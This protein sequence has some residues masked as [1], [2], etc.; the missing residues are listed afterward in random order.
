MLGAS[1]SR[2]IEH[3]ESPKA[4]LQFIHRVAAVT[5]CASSFLLVLARADGAETQ[6]LSRR[7]PQ[8]AADLAPVGRA[9][10]EQ[11]L[12]LSI[13]LPLRNR[14]ALNTLVQQLYDPASPSY[15]HYLT[16]E[17]FGDMFGA[18]EADYQAVISFMQ[19]NGLTV[20]K[21]HPNRLVVDV[22]GTVAEVERVMHVTMREYQHPREARKFYAPDVEPS[23][24]LS[25]PILE[26]SGLNNYSRRRPMLHRTPLAQSDSV[27]PK[28][29]SGPSSTYIGK[30]FR[31]AYVPGATNLTGTG[32]MVGLLQFDAYY[33]NDIKNYIT[34]AGISTSVVLTNVTVG[35]VVPKPSDGNGEVTLDI[36]MVISMAPGVSKI[37]VFEAT[38]DDSVSWSTMLSTMASYTN[39]HQFSCS[40]GDNSVGTPD[41][42]SE[43]I[44]LQ[45]AAQGQSFYN[46]SGDSDAFSGGIPFP[47][48]ST[49]I[50]QVGGTT[51]TMTGTG[52]AY[53]SE[54]VWN[55]GGGTGSSGGV[56]THFAI[57]YY[58]QGISM[59][60][61]KGSTTMRNV[62][63]VAL[64]ADNV[65][66]IADNGA[67]TGGVGGTSCAAPLW[68]GFTALINQQA[69]ANGQGPVGFLNPAVYTIGKG[70]SYSACFHDTTTGNNGTSTKYPAVTGFDL[71]TGWGTPTGTNLINALSGPAPAPGITSFSP[72][73]GFVNT[74]VTITGSNFVSASAVTFNGTSASFM[75]DS[76]SQITA[77]VPLT[78]TTGPIAVVTPSGTATSASSFTV[79]AGSPAPVVASF[80]PAYGPAGT[81]VVVTG[82]YFTNVSAVTFN[83]TSA[84]FTVNSLTQ[85]ATTV[86]PG[87]TT[88]PI[89]VVTAS[90]TAASASSFSVLSGDGSPAIASFTPASGMANSSVVITGVN[91]AGVT[92]VTFNGV[93]ASFT[94]NSLTQITATVPSAATTGPIAVTNPYGTGTSSTS[95]TL[96]ASPQVAISQIYGGGGN[97]SAPY[98]YDYIEL[99]NRGSVAVD[100]STWSVQYAKYNGS[101]WSKT[102]LTGTIQPGHYYLVQEATGG[103]VGS[104]LPIPDATGS[105]NMSATQGKVA[106]VENQTTLTVA[107]PAGGTGIAD[108]VGYGTATAYEGSGPAPAPSATTAIFRANSGAT[109]TD[110]NSADFTTGAPAPR[111]SGPG[112]SVPDLAVAVSHSGSFVQGG[113]GNSYT[114][115]VT[116][117]GTA[118]S[119]GT[120]TVIDTL[121]AGLTAT[122]ISGTGWAATLG[123]LTCTRSDALAAGATYPGIT[124]T[125]SVSTN[126]PASVTNTATVSGGGDT[127]LVNN[128]ANDPT[129]ITSSGGGVSYAGVLAGWDV[130][131]L[132]GGSGSFGTSPLSAS[133]NAQNLTVGGLTR[134]SGVGTSGTGAARA[135]GG[136]TFT[137]T[138]E[139]AATNASQFATFSIAAH[140]GYRVSFTNLSRLDYRRSGSGPTN[141]ELQ[142]QVGSGG[143]VDI[144]NLAYSSTSGSGASLGPFNLSGIS[145]LQNVGAGTNVTFRIVNWG[146]S[147]AGG[148]WYIYDVAAST[149]ND[150]EV[151]GTVVAPCSAPAALVPT[152]SPASTVC[153]GTAVTL[154][155]GATGGL[156]PY[157]YQWKTNGTAIPGATGSTYSI[158][159]P[160]VAD[161]LNYTVDITS[162]CGGTASTSPALALTV[163]AVPSTPTAGNNGPVC[164]GSALTLS[165]PT[166]SGA[167]YSWTG[168][169]GFTS[170][171]QNP[172]VSGSAIVSMSGTYYVT[173]V[174]SGCASAAGS[175]A[176]TVN[177]AS[178]G[179][180]ATP[181]VATVA[182]GTGT[183]ITLTGQTGDIVKWQYSTDGNNWSDIASTANPLPT[184]PLM[185][186]TEYRAV[187]QSGVCAAAASSVATI[188]ASALVAP[189]LSGVEKLSDTSIKLTFSGPQGQNYSVLETAEVEQLLASWNVLTNGTFGA[190][191][192]TFTDTSATNASRFYRITSP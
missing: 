81:S 67:T 190:S 147:N 140:T 175:T 53:S 162:S 4:M 89:S 173:V 74:T 7:L 19:A 78:A 105:M 69:A 17:Q 37:Y 65:Y 68:A 43:G 141:G 90:G 63:D 189:M 77:K 64:T 12:N 83:G 192:E 102:S 139:S 187:V 116:N 165:T 125:V 108:F 72:A 95:F 34:T 71:C 183:N 135:W 66:N 151:Q 124:V 172:M 166:V 120:V 164:A 30:D 110:D 145:A 20:T 118:A 150:L 96:L 32:Q 55:W 88:G 1:S 79:L 144:T 119:T 137:N 99:Y 138:S 146:A 136:T 153:A 21:T 178:A 27:G 45:M 5:V 167:T 94:V 2:L 148:T 115:M 159:S 121:P 59:T 85:I 60:A 3:K 170:P 130:S 101:S 86:P 109:D 29:G 11:R 56:S 25:V 54:T 80:S 111:N 15:R 174:V 133:T 84:S 23:L 13:G 42:T 16:P 131:G 49:N 107:N 18:T 185:Q 97:A 103:S 134:G 28:S 9:S 51:L 128:T 181:A 160:T 184:G 73:S 98:L 143:F 112:L 61:N 106:L 41:Y 6:K 82:Q 24:D 132:T 39:I 179:G 180:T 142:Y 123:T 188:S 33:T 36:Q 76:G 176:V 70:S 155:A 171:A 38:N 157:T 75:V 169:N 46:A 182:S 31:N 158:A 57:P 48:E 122:A 22:Q 117:V 191:P 26:I 8:V 10:A 104:A 168:P 152:A 163:N 87:A 44:F 113:V 177:R 14:E 161:A 186:T 114:I 126:A 52:A 127:N 91:F 149:A 129:T 156:T 47:S 40:W 35:S 93:S 50:T 154:A 62:P 100:L 92:A 58:Q